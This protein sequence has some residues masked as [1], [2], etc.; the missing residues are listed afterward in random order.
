MSRLC[1]FRVFVA[2]FLILGL[3]FGCSTDI[4][5]GLESAND[6][7]Y[8][9]DYVEAER[10]YRKLLNQLENSGDLDKGENKQRLLIL[11]RLGRINSLY[12]RDYTKAIED[13]SILVKDF[14]KTDEAFAARATVADI[15]HHKLGKSQSALD[16]FQK[17]VAQFPDK[18]RSRWAQLQIITI[19]LQL[20]NYEQARM[21]AEILVKRWSNSDE[22]RQAQFLIANSYFV[23]SRYTEAMATYT[24]LLEQSPDSEFAS[25]IN[26]ELANCLQGLGEDQQAL[27]HYYACLADHPNPLL[28]QRKIKKV[29]HRIHFSQESKGIHRTHR[30]RP[31]RTNP[32]PTAPAPVKTALPKPDSPV[33]AAPAPKTEV[34]KTEAPK[35][36]AQPKEPPPSVEE[37]PQAKPTPPPTAPP[38][39]NKQ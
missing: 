18:P 15:Y 27:T 14:A 36:E 21:E 20:K 7:L 26:F 39:A 32:T 4:Q 37:A 12:L 30:A 19:Y 16:E 10:L 2:A 1:R 17:L 38:P 9:H 22:A 33:K 24:Q 8:Q 29:R 28:V 35:A 13:Y 23:Q 3:N 31:K 6:L 5:P 11:E 25:L 34:P